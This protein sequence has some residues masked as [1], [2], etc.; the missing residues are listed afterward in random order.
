[1]TE[2][3]R[4][5][6]GPVDSADALQAA[7][8]QVAESHRD[9]LLL[10]RGQ[11]NLHP[12]VRSGL[13]RPDVRY[14]PD[15]DRGFSAI[16]G[17]I[18]GHESLGPKTVAF[19][20][21]VLQHYG[22][23]T[24]Y[25]DLTADALVAA[26]FATHKPDERRIVYAGIPL[27]YIDQRFYAPRK[28]GTGYVVVLAIPDA[29]TLKKDRR[30]FDI[31]TLGP[32]LRPQRQNAWLI[33]DRHPLL[34]D[35][36]EFWV[37]SIA[38]DCSKFAST[39]SA[40][41]LFPLPKEDGG[42]KILLS[43]PYV[44]V[45]AFWLQQLAEARAA[46]EMQ[47]QPEKSEPP[48]EPKSRRRIDFGMRALPL[49]EYPDAAVSKDEYD[50]KWNDRTLTEPRPMQEWVKWNFDLNARFPGIKGNTNASTKITLSPRVASLLAKAQGK[51]V[52]QLRWPSLGTNEL[53]FTFAQF[54]YDKVD[55]IEY[56]YK[57]VW[58]HQDK[59]LVFEHPMTADEKSLDVHAG[60]V[61][62]FVGEELLRQKVRSSC[63]CD[64]P[65]SHD[66]RVSAMLSLSAFI[67]IEEVVLVP[68]PLRIPNWYFAL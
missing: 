57:G 18:L 41:H 11:N 34:P 15:V 55:D 59:D 43:L 10:F 5:V 36:N 27:R 9:K 35:P 67:E 47:E 25:V 16:A 1:M 63:R 33:Y 21:A 38:V 4:P 3:E 62:E 50:H 29:E 54:G 51:E 42:F 53:F 31:S 23:P 19:R 52:V 22:F 24:H 56:P 65:E 44:E 49:P 64:S 66:A 7:V 40:S 61:Y 28:E 13:S 32:F 46:A 14:E 68:H 30:L 8:K 60:H 37:A 48:E 12:T 2:K 45:P 58:L 17:S 26:W 20:K 39:L 6:I